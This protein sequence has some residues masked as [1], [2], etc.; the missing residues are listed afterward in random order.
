MAGGAAPRRGMIVGIN[1]T[2]LVDITLVLL[3]IFIV[4]ARIV[5]APA[6]PMDLPQAATGQ[7]VQV[8]FSVMLPQDGTLLVNGS[9]VADRRELTARAATALQ[10]NPELRAVVHAD[11]DVAHRQVLSA[12]DALREA[13]VSRIAFGVAPAP[14]AGGER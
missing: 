1:V 12:M 3:I 9:P 13:G 14:P 2:P 10:E 5:V 11:G 7:E 4:T 6:V 8:V